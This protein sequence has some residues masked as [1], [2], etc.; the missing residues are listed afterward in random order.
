MN[1]SLGGVGGGI[2]STR[3]T[4]EGIQAG[5]N[6]VIAGLSTQVASLFL[7]MLCC[8][9]FAVMVIRHKDQRLKQ[10]RALRDTR[11]FRLFLYSKAF[12]SCL[13]CKLTGYAIRFGF[14]NDM[15]LC[16]VNF[17]NDRAS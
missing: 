11:S 4:P 8:L 7:F 9:H 3:Q 13:D 1:L 10:F 12:R 6:I 14:G 16:E 2:S 17:Q 15:H 5:L